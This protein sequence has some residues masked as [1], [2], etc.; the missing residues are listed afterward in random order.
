MSKLLELFLGV[1]EESL[2]KQQLEDFHK[3]MSELYAS[4]HLELGQIEKRKG[5]YFLPNPELT[6]IAVERKWRATNDGQR[7]IELKSYIRA[8]S[9]HLKS[10][11]ARLYSQ[12]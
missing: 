3:E 10:L 9:A 6:G 11:K 7:E 1:K 2:S 4:M 5:M 12:Y 8:T